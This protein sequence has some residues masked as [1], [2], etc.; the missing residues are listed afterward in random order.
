MTDENSG[1]IA[2]NEED[3]DLLE[4]IATSE[5]QF[6]KLRKLGVKAPYHTEF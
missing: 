5:K 6:Y 3:S 1:V 2:M 4:S